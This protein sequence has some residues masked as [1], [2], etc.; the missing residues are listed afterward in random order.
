MG[1]GIG[2]T[3]GRWTVI[4]ETRRN[5]KRYYCCRCE[6]GTEKEVYYRSLEMGLSQSCGCLRGE[7]LRS[8]GEDLTGKK[9]GKLTVLYR[10]SGRDGYWV[11]ECECGGRTSVI[12]KSLREGNTHSCGCIQREIASRTGTRTVGKNAEKQIAINMAYRT[13]F[14][15]IENENLPKN[16]TSGCKGVWWDKSRGKWQSYI[17]VHGKR[18]MLGRFSRKEDAIL[19]RKAAE[20]EYFVPLIEKK[21]IEGDCGNGI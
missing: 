11:C 10:D 19:A 8:K 1:I 2:D 3:I 21:K 5:G 16:N 17:Q 4:G 18:V 12:A 20:D 9:V 13:N 14:Q 6:C 15:V 7:L